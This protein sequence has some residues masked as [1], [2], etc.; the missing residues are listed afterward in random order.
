MA[1][2]VTSRATVLTPRRVPRWALDKWA[3]KVR[4]MH[5]AGT[6][7]LWQEEELNK[8]PGW[9]WRPR[10][11]ANAGNPG[12][13]S[14][15]NAIALLQAEA[16][17]IGRTPRRRE[18]HEAYIEGRGPSIPVL[19]RLFGS[20]SAAIRASGLPFL[21]PE[22]SCREVIVARLKDEAARL[23]RTPLRMD[24]DKACHER[25]IV[26]IRVIIRVFGS[27]RNACLAAGLKPPD[28]V[29]YT[30][31]QL[32]DQLNSEARRHGGTVSSPQ[33]HRA[34]QQGRVAPLSLF[35]S[36]FGSWTNALMEAGIIT[37]P[38]RLGRDELLEQLRDEAKRLGRAP[39]HNEICEASRAGRTASAGAFKRAFGSWAEALRAA[40]LKTCRS[41][42]RTF[43]NAD[44][45]TLLKQLQTEATL[46][47]RCPR[48]AD[49]RTAFRQGRTA[50]VH[51]FAAVFGSFSRALIAAGLAG[52]E[53]HRNSVASD[54]ESL[55][56]QFQE[57]AAALGRVPTMSDWA[58]AGDE[59]RVASRAA[60]ERTFGT[61]NNLARAAG[62]R[63]NLDNRRARSG[64]PP[65]D[66]N[67]RI[68]A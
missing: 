36:R 56:S 40:G 3:G 61:W 17:K 62:F 57:M 14:R 37:R 41:R 26:G 58:R 65:R 47:R 53:R 30:K 63:P 38:R 39:T 9:Q 54:R 59:D 28:P 19:Q 55:L 31:K 20:V 7:P 29:E 23:G 50:S 64:A 1:V 42:D 8:V 5:F 6:L 25:R 16:E 32:I 11:K 51:T 33:M 22:D 60:V 13:I 2:S 12:N 44:A 27:Y 46:L 35:Q 34:H 24:L 18:I 43:R 4:A 67:Q 66:R 52:R 10:R 15:E 68:P 49:I 48:Q 45:E 21:M